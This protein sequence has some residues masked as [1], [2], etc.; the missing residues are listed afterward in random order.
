MSCQM[1]LRRMTS[2]RYRIRWT[3]YNTHS[4]ERFATPCIYYVKH[5]CI[6]Y[7]SPQVKDAF[8][9]STGF[10]PVP[11]AI[12]VDAEY[13]QLFCGSTVVQQ[14]GTL[15][16]DLQYCGLLLLLLALHVQIQAAV[17]SKRLEGLLSGTLQ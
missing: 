8:Q 12:K 13:C 17:D 10:V 7:K 5:T 4:S 3:R 1:R 11:A 2:G 14:Q 15:I 16:V 6:T 9:K